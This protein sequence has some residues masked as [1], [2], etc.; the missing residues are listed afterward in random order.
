[1]PGYLR[2]IVSS[3]K[4]IDGKGRELVDRF[5]NEP[6]KTLFYQM[7]PWDQWHAV[8]VAGRVISE[9]AE[10]GKVRLMVLVKACLLHD[11][12]KVKGYAGFMLRLLVSFIRRVLP[13]YRAK[14]AQ[15]DGGRLAHALYVDLV[16]PDRG[17]YM[18]VSVGISPEVA[19][20][21]RR[22]HDTPLTSDSA[23]LELLRR[24]DS[25]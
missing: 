4:G 6:E 1:M 23:E 10:N 11:V 25:W 21:I 2:R 20:L 18:A 13:G 16:H 14:H 22:H 12:G 3:R 19:E 5:L 9:T 8:H 17:A 24:A 7:A 15:R